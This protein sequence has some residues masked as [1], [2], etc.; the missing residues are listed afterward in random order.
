MKPLVLTAFTLLLFC[1]RQ[2]Q[3]Q[4]YTDLTQF[5]NMY[6][7]LNP[8]TTGLEYDLDAGIAARPSVS[9]LYLNVQSNIL[10]ARHHGLGVNYSMIASFPDDRTQQAHLNYNYQFL[11]K[12][13]RRI[14]IG[15]ALGFQSNAGNS[16]TS[17]YSEPYS[18]AAPD[19]NLGL[20]YRGKALIAGAG[21]AHVVPFFNSYYGPQ[22]NVHASYLF[23]LGKQKNFSLRPQVLV[24]NRDEY[25]VGN[26]NLTAAWK[27]QWW[28]G[29]S[30][31]YEFYGNAQYWSLMTGWDIKRRFRVGYSVDVS[32]HQTKFGPFIS[33]YHEIVFA[34]FMNRK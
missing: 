8:A 18:V 16:G 19:L 13:T 34:F 6:A 4:S 24:C 14:S 17:Y 31:R 27:E 1:A 10:L 20:A 25:F 28:L 22:F 9:D 12:D 5:W 15:A 3:A 32:G 21:V 33:I 11:L 7:L 30:L 26:F 29:A 2:A 23:R